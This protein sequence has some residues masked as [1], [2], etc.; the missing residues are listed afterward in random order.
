MKKLQ[1]KVLL[2]EQKKQEVTAKV[3][4][5]SA[6]KDSK[7]DSYFKNSEHTILVLDKKGNIID[8]ND[9]IHS[10]RR[11]EIIGQSAYKFIEKEYHSVVKKA[12]NI[13][14]TK[15]KYQQYEIS[16]TGKKGQKA[17][18]SSRVTPHFENKKVVAAIIDIVDITE[19]VV[20]KKALENSEEKFKKLSDSAFEGIAIHKDGKVVEIN[21][22]LRKTFQYSDK[23]MIN[24]PILKFIHPDF[25]K[26]VFE[27]VKN[28]IETPYEVQM[29]RKGKK[30]FWAELLGTEII[31]KGEP[32]RV[33]SIRDISKYKANEKKIKESE[34]KFR[35]LAENATDLI[36]R[37]SV[38]PEVQYEYVSPSVKDIT[39]YSA[40][41]FYKDPFL[42]FKIIHPDDVP[43]LGESEKLLKSKAK[44]SNIKGP[45]IVVR[46][47]K[48]DG[49]VIWTETRSKPVFDNNKRL[50]AIEGISRDVTAQKLSEE[51]SKESE[52]SHIHF[53]QEIPS[54]VIIYVD[55]IVVF[56]NKAAFEIFGIK[57]RTIENVSNLNINNYILPKYHK[58][59]ADRAK[60][61]LNGEMLHFFEIEVKTPAGEILDLEI[62]SK[63]VFHN[64]KKGIQTIF[65]NISQRKNTDRVLKESERAL[66]S[67]MNNLPGM[68]YRCDNDKNWTM[69]FVSK[70]FKELTGYDPKDVVDNKTMSF[71]EI[72]HPDD[73]P[74]LKEEIQKALKNRLPYEFEYRIIKSSGETKWVLEKGEGVFSEEGKLLFLEGFVFDIDEKKQY[75]SELKQSG[76]NYKNLVDKSPDGIFIFNP[77][78]GKIIFANPSAFGIVEINSSE[79]LKN[80]TV[81]DFILPEFQEEVKGRMRANYPPE[82]RAFRETTVKTA[83]GNLVELELQAEHVNYNGAAAIQVTMHKIGIEKQL[84]K[85]QLR[86]QIAEETNVLLEQEITA[87]KVIQLK[88]LESQKYTRLIINGSIDMICASDRK[89]LI[90]EFNQ[91]AQA[92]FGYTVNEVLG[93]HVSMLYEDPKER[94]KITED[95]LFKNG[96]YAGEVTNV[97]K[98]GEKFISYLSASIL[99]NDEGE[100]IGAMGVSRDISQLKKADETLRTQ[101]AK[102]NAII[103]S[104]SHV[105]WT[106]DKNI[107]L[108]TFNQNY[109]KQLIK[110][111]GI[112]A[113]VGLS[114]ISGD[115]V[116]SQ[117]H[118]NFWIKKY[119]R[120]FAGEPQYFE[121]QFVEKDGHESWSEIYL[122]PISDESGFVIEVSGIGHDVTEKK[123]SEERIRQSLQE[124][125]ILLKEVHHRVKNNLQV[126]S[127]I[128]NLQSSYVKDEGT[129]DILKESQNRIK[130]MAFIHESLYQ[131]KDFSSI[132]FTEYVVNLS[133]NL[134]HSYS[135]FDNEIKLNLDIQ[136][137]FLNLDL[138]IPCGLIIN[139]IVS[140][141]LK[142][143]FV[144]NSRDGEITIKMQV[145]D[146]DLVLNIGDNGKG[147]PADLDFRNTESLG[148][149]LV[150]TLTDQLSGTI[151]LNVEKGT[152]YCIKFKQNQI[153]N[154]I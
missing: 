16:G 20:T 91:A 64:G 89:G 106:V 125:E 107:C 130:S 96:V 131:T 28:K 73:A 5:T 109:D 136:N 18:Y 137:V 95:E 92:T 122:N 108:T 90:T 26:I 69:R 42:G 34:E 3:K 46:W 154:R 128:L 60:R 116:S 115:S 102:F 72:T 104:S 14:F 142:Y 78:D 38:Y 39:G 76:E 70:G 8:N 75:E 114:M 58:E 147:L 21:N 129:L 151:E 31:Y 126:I 144:E 141:A 45:E 25:H 87:R 15:G 150:V 13:V 93:K 65:N 48:K 9:L 139:E 105:I 56:A 83:K 81:L 7:W 61:V 124:K 41:D 153:K 12:L 57:E 36:Y 111:Y 59:I 113:N 133:Q 123:I 119:E 22:A 143:A 117:E 127:S 40:E 52:E 118:N 110:R 4:K 82:S 120:A 54:G 11:N 24:Q 35:M 140:N 97:R 100:L 94:I 99:K 55:Y 66:S 135:N 74:F 80:K 30:A 84:A 134:L 63:L 98:N 103:E 17:F 152:N 101:S 112:R 79:D 149:Q 2:L 132:N 32:A 145:I 148:L 10:A 68:A 71:A 62:K 19:V 138:A 53:L 85:E 23:E 146:D 1:R 43:L 6:P 121:T 44:V 50:I 67:L 47:I 37:C 49:S 29:L 77:T 88:L 33:T 86:A 27:N 51:K